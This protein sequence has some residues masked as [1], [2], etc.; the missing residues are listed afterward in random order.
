MQRLI[1][2]YL[3]IKWINKTNK[4]VKQNKNIKTKN[5]KKKY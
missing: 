3:K 2:K 1:K 4:K 5:K